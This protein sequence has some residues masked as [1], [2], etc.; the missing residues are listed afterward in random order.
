ME[1]KKEVSSLAE[2]LLWVEETHQIAEEHGNDYL[3]YRGHADANYEFLPS[4]YRKSP[5]GKSYRA[6]EHHLFQDMIRRDPAPFASD[7]STLEKLVRMQHYGLP[8]RLLDLT[9]NPLVALY[10]ACERPSDITGEVL[11]FPQKNSHVSFS[12]DIPDIALAGIE[13]ACS[14]EQLGVDAIK[15]LQ[16][17]LT[18]Q[19]TRATEHPEFNTDYQT[20]LKT[21]TEILTVACTQK[22]LLQTISILQLV[23]EEQL[24]KL[25][26]KWDELFDKSLASST[27]ERDIISNAYVTLLKFKEY[28]TEHRAKIISAL[29]KALHINN[30]SEKSNLYKFFQEFTFFYFFLPSINN[31]RILRQQGAFV[32]CPPGKT[33]YWKLDQYINPQRIKIA[34]SA[35]GKILKD[36]ARIGMTRSFIFPESV[37]L[38]EDVKS[39]YP[40]TPD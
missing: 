22:D 19:I 17:F 7:K 25:I 6:V 24:S 40:A 23:E 21:C 39:R 33:D 28:L 16:Q 32:I 34:G 4:A 20:T 37:E 36:L 15:S 5:Q 29:C 8:T 1:N 14:I 18:T 27:I 30:H 11:L 13:R 38:V 9:Q 35:K 2:Y 3:F 12:S 26:E 10:F 31:E